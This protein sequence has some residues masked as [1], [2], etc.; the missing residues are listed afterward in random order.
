[1]G[2]ST[3]GILFY[4]Y[5]WP[6]ER[7]IESVLY[8][9]LDE[10]VEEP[11]SDEWVEIVLKRRGIVDPYKSWPS[12]EEIADIGRA[13][14]DEEVEAIVAEKGGYMRPKGQ[15]DTY[16][17]KNIG[18]E[19]FRARSEVEAATTAW[20]EA[21]DEVKREYGCDFATHCSGEAPMAYLY[22]VE[23][24]YQGP[25][26]FHCSRGEVLP[27]PITELAAI[28]TAEW[29]ARLARFIADLGIS[30]EAR[31]EYD[32][33]PLGPGWFLVSYWGG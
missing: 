15:G 24:K 29:D 8:P 13:L 9:D 16:A 20:R 11:T 31:D 22:I 30:L 14:S 5:A 33:A 25:G 2:V 17:W 10:E 27:V 3:D 32:E 23:G 28:D 4:G 12:E 7:S 19:V 18:F 6:G 1:M 26:R 21:Q